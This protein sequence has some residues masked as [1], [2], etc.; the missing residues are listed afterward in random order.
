MREDFLPICKKDLEERDIEQLDFIIVTG[1]AYVDHPSFG[2]AIISRVLERY[3]YKVGII[4]QPDWN[5]LEEFKKLGKPKYAF[6]VNSGNIDSMVNHY[7]VNKKRRSKDLYTP[8]DSIDKRPDRAVIVYSNKIREAYKDA[9]IIIGGIEASLRRL[10]HYDYWDDRIRNSILVDSGADLLIYGMGEKTII[11]IADALKSGINIQDLSYIKGTVYRTKSLKYL[12]DYIK[13][14]TFKEIKESKKKYA[15]SFK[16][17]MKNTDSKNAEILVE[18]YKDFY[19]VQNTPQEPLTQLELDDVYNLPYTRRYHPK[20]EK[21][22]G[23]SALKRVENSITLNR[24]C[25][26][27]CSFCALNFH[28]G[29]VIQSRSKKSVLLETDK[30]I[31]QKNFKGYIDDIGGPTANFNTKACE[32]QEK[33]GVCKEKS[34]LYPKPC[35]NLNATHSKYLDILRSV[36]NKREVKK[37]FIKSGIR[38]DYLL[39][40]KDKSFFKELCEHHISGQ[41]RVA[42]EHISNEV[43]NAMGKPEHKVYEKFVKEYN[44][45]NNKKQYLVPYFISS[46]PGS[47]LKDAIKLAEYIRDLNYTPEQVQDFY[48]TP[49]TLSTCM[50]YTE[51]DPRNMKKIYVPK[52]YEEKRMQRALLQYKYRRNYKYVEKALKK[53]NRMDLIGYKKICLIRPRNIKK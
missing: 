33:Y 49:G 16:I 34:C 22:G 53:A 14:P 17:Q 23:I 25:F 5:D 43:L 29:R 6:L 32:K 42:P 44:K 8:N 50:Y 15:E 24:G 36:R 1:D 3:G 51:I 47:T 19:I 41:L 2:T 30:I 12:Y 7:T 46:H 28:Q 26:G 45:Y 27:E 9:N 37:V 48:P 18:Q 10:A 4:A 35:K 13:L 11:E 20:Y 31:N 39:L 21:D 52:S 40:D 38:F